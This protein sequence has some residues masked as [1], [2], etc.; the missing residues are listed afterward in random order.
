MTCFLG[1]A[2]QLAP[3]CGA[4][5]LYIKYKYYLSA[6]YIIVSITFNLPY[7]AI[8]LLSPSIS[9]Q[10]T[11]P[12]P[13]PS[14]WTPSAPEHSGLFRVVSVLISVISYTVLTTTQSVPPAF[15]IWLSGQLKF[16]SCLTTDAL[17]RHF[18]HYTTLHSVIPCHYTH[19][20]FGSLLF[21]CLLRATSFCHTQLAQYCQFPSWSLT[22][23]PHSSCQP[24]S[25]LLFQPSDFWC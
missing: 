20:S 1:T 16:M 22:A 3:C 12:V 5:P 7:T 4:K 19:L 24:T 9:L 11:P 17:F 2:H 10:P 6:F 18:R 14:V 13:V 21:L 25:K 23:T 8:L 15:Y